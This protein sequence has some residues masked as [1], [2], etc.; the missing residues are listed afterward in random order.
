MLLATESEARRIF[1]SARK[2]LGAENLQMLGKS[3]QKI[4]SLLPS[5]QISISFTIHKTF[6]YVVI[7][8]GVQPKL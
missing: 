3:I 5:N 2:A 6:S 4:D 1:Q 7:I 8:P